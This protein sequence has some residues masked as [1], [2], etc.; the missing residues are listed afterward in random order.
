[1]VFSAPAVRMQ[2]ASSLVFKEY[3]AD[4]RAGLD[5]SVLEAM[6]AYLES[7]PFSAGMELLSRSAWPCRLVESDGVV[8]GFVM[9]AIPPE[10]FVQM[11]LASGSSRQVGE[12]QHL[13][14]GPVFLSQRGI[15]VS[16]RQ[17]CELLVEVARG[18]AVFHRHS[19]AVGDVSP[20]NLKRHDFRAAPRRVATAGRERC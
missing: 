15:G 19:V 1:M 20:K 2:Y 7:L 14:N 6:P 13:L 17:R 16:D 3:R 8:V 4:V 12:F 10:F 11:R 18:L 9:P 5:V